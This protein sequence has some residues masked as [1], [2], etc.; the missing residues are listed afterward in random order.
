MQFMRWATLLAESLQLFLDK[1]WEILGRLCSP[2]QSLRV[3]SLQNRLGF[4]LL[5]L[6]VVFFFASFG[7]S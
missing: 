3:A 5:L 2:V 1:S 7:R 4:L 6:F